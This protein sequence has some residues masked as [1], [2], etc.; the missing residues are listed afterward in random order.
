MGASH[1]GIVRA[2]RLLCNCFEESNERKEITRL[3]A[4]DVGTH[5]VEACGLANSLAKEVG[6]DP[7]F[8]DIAMPSKPVVEETVGFDLANAELPDEDI[9]LG[10]IGMEAHDH[11][12]TGA[13]TDA[14]V[15][16]GEDG[17]GDWLDVALEDTVD[18]SDDFADADA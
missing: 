10:E 2:E 14:F 11:E 15:H 1:C 8:K 17:S 4:A 5:R 16:Q 18:Q 7:V 12:R 9:P 3:G 6:M 13:M